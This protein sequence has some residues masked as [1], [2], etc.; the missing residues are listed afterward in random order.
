MAKNMRYMVQI[1]GHETGN[2]GTSWPP[3]FPDRIKKKTGFKANAAKAWRDELISPVAGY[4]QMYNPN[5]TIPCSELIRGYG[6]DR[7][8]VRIV[9]FKKEK[10]S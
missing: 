4:D 8:D 9:M 1:R 5:R 3:F 6:L 10:R 2:W 7:D